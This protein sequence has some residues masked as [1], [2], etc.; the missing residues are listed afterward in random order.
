MSIQHLKKKSD[1]IYL[2][3]FQ[4]TNIV[5]AMILGKL[6]EKIFVENIK[7]LITT[8]TKLE[9]LYKDGLQ[10]DQFLPF[11]NLILPEYVNFFYSQA[12]QLLI[13]F[14]SG[15]IKTPGF[16]MPFG[17]RDDLAATKTLLKRSGL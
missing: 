7:I 12:I 3:E 1:L 16:M 8:N 10:R 15:S 17:S 6:F 2:D 13:F 14:P 9:N 5:D 4:V 11:I